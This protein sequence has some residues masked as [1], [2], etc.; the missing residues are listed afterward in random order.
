MIRSARKLVYAIL[1]GLVLVAS[2]ALAATEVVTPSEPHG[3]F[4][5]QGNVNAGGNIV[6]VA[7]SHGG[8]GSFEFILTTQSN[9]SMFQIAKIPVITVDDVEE[10][11]WDFKSDANNGQYPVVKLEYYSLNPNRSGTLVYR[12]PGS[13]TPGA[14]QHVV[15]GQASNFWDTDSNTT[16]TLAEWQQDLKGVLVNY[17]VA[18]IGTTSGSQ[19]ASTSYIDY[20]HLKASRRNIDTTWDFE[21]TG[22]IPTPPPAPQVVT[23]LPTST[24]GWSEKQGT[25]GGATMELS[26]DQ[27]F[28]PGN[29]G[30]LRF[31]KPNAAGAIIQAA[32]IP[33]IRASDIR[34]V[35]WAFYSD[36]A[37]NFPVVKIEYF[38]QGR[39]G[40]LVYDR[41]NIS[42][43]SNTW[44]E[45]PVDNNKDLW[46]STEF[47]SGDKRTLAQWQQNLGNIA[48][49][50]FVVGIG[51]TG[52]ASA[53]VTSYVDLVHLA[54][55]SSNTYWDFE[56]TSNVQPPPIPTLSEWGLIIL[57]LLM[58]GIAV[59]LIRKNQL[60]RV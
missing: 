18:G 22:S 33:G 5:K 3:W 46:W 42:Y 52:G 12:F 34:E 28:G 43:T 2:P 23:V 8:N 6:S 11:D 35:G 1:L 17:F 36:S 21:G 60:E 13:V 16:K 4:D 29:T 25:G 54:T 49:N 10:L 40:T 51:S 37:T 39:S 58:T 15:V 59:F 55:S 14:W 9:G 30:S 26:T 27:P 45:V 31:I 32:R 41:S 24:S 44:R 38:G 7:D 57:S 47:G 50:Y 20:I 56:A 53:A 19:T 48:I